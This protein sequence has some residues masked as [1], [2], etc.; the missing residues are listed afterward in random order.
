MSHRIGCRWA[1][2]LSLVAVTGCG[3]DGF[4]PSVDNVSGSYVATVLTVEETSGTVDYLAIGSA[5]EVTLHPDGTVEGE[6]FV[7]SLGPGGS[8]I[9]IALGG[10]WSLDG[11][12]VTI[13]SIQDTFLQDVVFTATEGRLEGEFVGNGVSVQVRLDKPVAE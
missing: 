9:D 1:L 4:E 13:D 7:P 3:D 5:L 10:T 12:Q 8:D 11:D 6:L 2:P